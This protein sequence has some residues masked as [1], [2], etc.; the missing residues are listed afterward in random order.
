[1]INIILK[2]PQEKAQYF[3]RTQNMKSFDTHH[4]LFS[5]IENF[6]FPRFESELSGCVESDNPRNF[7]DTFNWVS[8]T[9][10]PRSLSKH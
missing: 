8:S 7:D 6:V 2:V 1:M 10:L 3:S 5:L 9:L 4:L